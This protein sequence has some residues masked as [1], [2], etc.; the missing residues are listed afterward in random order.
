MS[1]S[2]EELKQSAIPFLISLSTSS[3]SFIG[4]KF[5][6]AVKI[7]T[8]RKLDTRT[9]AARY[10]GYISGIGIAPVETDYPESSIR[11]Y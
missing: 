2:D 3:L 1:G 8:V 7:F 10:S 5:L 11:R 4:K 9:I 6:E